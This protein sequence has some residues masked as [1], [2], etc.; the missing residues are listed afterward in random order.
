MIERGAI[1]GHWVMLQNCHLLVSWL[2]SLE[3]IFDNLQKP[4]KAFRLWLTT[5]P[6]DK[7]PLGIL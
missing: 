3:A 4:D 6:T 1:Q 5:S 2:P 7:F